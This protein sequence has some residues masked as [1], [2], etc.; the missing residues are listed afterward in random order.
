M[1]S[2]RT[3]PGTAGAC[4]GLLLA[5]T[6]PAGA[7]CYYT[8]QGQFCVDDAP[9]T[10]RSG[11][12]GIGGGYRTLCVRACDGYYFPISYA[13]DRSRFKTDAAICEA[14]YP[15]GEASLYVHHT[16]GEDATEAVSAATGEPLARQSFAFSYRSTYDKSCA[17]LLHVGS[18]APLVSV[19]KPPVPEAVVAA[20]ASRGPVPPAAAG[21]VALA[22][23][24]QPLPADSEAVVD[25]AP[26]AP[27]RLNSDGMR[28]VGRAADYEALDSTGGEP[29][30]VAP[31][32]PSLAS[33]EPPVAASILP[34]PFDFFRKRKAPPEPDAE[35]SD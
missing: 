27:E 12:D 23:A 31:P 25:D 28:I 20:A 16:I 30:R 5:L 33:D 10:P 7:A 6:I 2:A 24:R 8:K 35:P 34:N 4:L 19:N 22:A 18:G 32:A 1:R 26:A 17:A 29:K 14:F 13:T 21:K 3:S 9:A 11:Q 15:P